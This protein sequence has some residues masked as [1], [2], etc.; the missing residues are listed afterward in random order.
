MFSKHYCARHISG[1]VEKGRLRTGDD[2]IHPMNLCSHKPHDSCFIRRFW[3]PLKFEY[4]CARPSG[5]ESSWLLL[6]FPFAH[7]FQVSGGFLFLFG[8]G[9]GQCLAS[10]FWAGQTR[11]SNNC[12][13]AC[14]RLRRATVLL[15]TQLHS[16]HRDWQWLLHRSSG[17]PPGS[18]PEF[19]TLA[20]LTFW[21]V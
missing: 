3:C 4:Y 21:I 20:L 13:W 6:V 16:P 1:S 14:K 9:R 17:L 7:S 18:N 8:D 5:R 2:G 15:H 10:V 11:R 12:H 19:S